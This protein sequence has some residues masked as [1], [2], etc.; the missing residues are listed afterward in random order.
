MPDFPISALPV[1]SSAYP[2]SL[3][4]HGNTTFASGQIEQTARDFEVAFLA[5]T[6]GHMGLDITK[7]VEGA[8]PFASLVNRAYAEQLVE[9]GGI[10]LAEN[11]VRSL[12]HGD[13]TN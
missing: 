4:R 2:Q 6:L 9:R 5:E 7:G 11:I 3:S 8:A 1:T 10:G 13:D 12:A